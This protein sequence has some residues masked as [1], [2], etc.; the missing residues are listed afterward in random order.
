MK[1]RICEKP[2]L[3]IQGEGNYIG[4]PCVFVRFSGCNL[5][6]PGCDTKYHKDGF[7]YTTEEIIKDIK[8]LNPL[9]KSVVFTGGEPLLYQAAIVEIIKALGPNF[10]PRHSYV[11]YDFW[12]Y[13]IETNGI[14]SPDL[15]NKEINGEALI[16]FNISPKLKRFNSEAGRLGLYKHWILSPHF[17]IIKPVISGED[18]IKEVEEIEREL[19]IYKDKIYLMAEG[20]TKQEQEE[21][22]EKVLNLAIKYGYNF[23]PRLHILIWDKKRGV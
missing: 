4:V 13:Q 9:T 14:I 20:A 19:R 7:D 12:W 15:L 1:I 5:N 6:C 16:Q 2:F 17:Y 21:K 23:T 22:M 11:N 8:K 3:S 10:A 18:D